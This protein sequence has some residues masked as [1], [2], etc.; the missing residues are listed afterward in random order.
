MELNKLTVTLHKVL[1]YQGMH[2]VDCV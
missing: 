1:T 2:H